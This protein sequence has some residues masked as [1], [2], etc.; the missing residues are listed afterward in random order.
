MTEY[1]S[2][3]IL[4]QSEWTHD[5][6]LQVETSFCH[7]WYTTLNTLGSIHLNK[8]FIHDHLEQEMIRS[9]KNETLHKVCRRVTA[10]EAILYIK[11]PFTNIIHVSKLY[12]TKQCSKTC[13]DWCLLYPLIKNQSA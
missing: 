3:I 9:S 1:S 5:L 6:D 2:S 11:L 7:I 13:T 8:R 12:I 4:I 10:T